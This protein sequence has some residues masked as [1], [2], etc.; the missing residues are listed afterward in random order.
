MITQTFRIGEDI[1]IALDVAQ[2]D[3]A[4]VASLTA[5]MQRSIS[6]DSFA[7]A[8]GSVAIP[9]AVGARAAEGE[10]PAGWNLTLSAAVTADLAPGVYAVD[11]TA[12]GT[13][14]EIE[15]TDETLFIRLTRAVI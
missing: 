8:R 1:T 11:A 12:T 5:K 13:G 6:A 15:L 2:G 7:P 3:V 4:D 9:F 10:I 14:D